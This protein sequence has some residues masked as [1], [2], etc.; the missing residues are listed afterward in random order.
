M[1]K[2]NFG[3]FFLIVNY[4]VLFSYL[5][6]Y[7][8]VLLTNFAKMCNNIMKQYSIYLYKTISV[9]ILYF[10]ISVNAIINNKQ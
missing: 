10:E 2:R 9:V 1:L 8:Y 7:L 6:L 5:S 3:S 4:T